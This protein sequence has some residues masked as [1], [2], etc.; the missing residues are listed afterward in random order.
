MPA[1]IKYNSKDDV[2][3]FYNN[4]FITA[5]WLCLILANFSH[6]YGAS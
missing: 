3:L 2:P 1:T 6:I 4:N 5:R